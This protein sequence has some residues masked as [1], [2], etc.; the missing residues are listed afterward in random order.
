MTMTMAF[1][2]D[3]GVS[4]E[5]PLTER[6]VLD[7]KAGDRVL[8]VASGGE[9]PLSLISLTD[10]L[11]ITAVDISQAQINLC[12]IKLAAALCLG[13]PENGQFL[14]FDFMK[15]Q[16]RI[17]IYRDVICQQLTEEETLFWNENLSIVGQG[18]ISAGRFEQYIAKMRFFSNLFIGKRNLQWL[19]DCPNLEDQKEIFKKYIAS[20]KSLQMLF[21]VAF[22]P[23]VYK[24]RGLQEKALRHADKSTGER[25][26][27]KFESFCTANLASQNYFLQ[28][29]LTGRCQTPGAFPHYLQPQNRHRLKNFSD[30]LQFETISFE[31]KIREEESGVFNKIHL[32]NLGD[33]MSEKEFSDLKDLLLEKCLPGTILCSR[34]LQ[35]NQFDAGFAPFIFDEKCSEMA[36]NTDRFP[37]YTIFRL[38]L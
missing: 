33:W 4:Q 2:F 1:L 37:F 7:L 12:R 27:R 19:I 18:V 28:Y 29:F 35:K 3:F 22:H 30:Q 23:A 9:V 8:S 14:G 15:P 31:K 36:Q 11:H 6:R 17:E 38:E 34:Y 10:N 24:N 32:S 5:D 25:F 26:Y 13:F 21:R 20:R 16:Q